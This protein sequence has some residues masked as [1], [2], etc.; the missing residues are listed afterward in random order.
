MV[1]RRFHHVVPN[2]NFHCQTFLKNAKF[3]LFGNEMPVGK[4]GCEYRLTNRGS[5]TGYGYAQFPLFCPSF[6]LPFTSTFPLP[7]PLSLSPFPVIICSALSF[8]TFPQHSTAIH[9]HYCDI[10]YVA[11]CGQRWLAVSCPSLGRTMRWTYPYSIHF[12]NWMSKCF[13]IQE[14]TRWQSF[15]LGTEQCRPVTIK[16]RSRFFS[17]N[18]PWSQS[19]SFTY[20]HLISLD[21]FK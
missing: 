19:A 1:A 2:D 3:D 12:D 4:S 16:Q 8:T 11:V 5:P 21:A 18:W 10:I 17:G 9:K 15:I 7:P 20:T 13:Q 14:Q 6:P